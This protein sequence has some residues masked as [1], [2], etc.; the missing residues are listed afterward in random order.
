[1]GHGTGRMN[2]AESHRGRRVR[3]EGLCC[4]E[5]RL[6][7]RSIPGGA[8]RHLTCGC[9][10]PAERRARHV[11]QAQRLVEQ[12]KNRQAI[13]LAV[14]LGPGPPASAVASTRERGRSGALRPS[15]GTGPG[16]R[17][18]LSPH[19]QPTPTYGR[20]VIDGCEGRWSISHAMRLQARPTTRSAIRYGL[21][22]PAS[23]ALASSPQSTRALLPLPRASQA[24]PGM[25]AGSSRPPRPSAPP[26]RPPLSRPPRAGLPCTRPR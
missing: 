1:M 19:C 14:M 6:R 17:R 23:S 2:G 5:L 13:R 21:D 12:S 4:W 22:K 24:R 16:S 25:H 20:S 11:K 18:A 8:L 26:R 3:Q 10:P 15:V 7:S 9:R